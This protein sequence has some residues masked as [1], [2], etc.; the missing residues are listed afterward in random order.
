MIFL[1]S[2]SSVMCGAR[3]PLM[4]ENLLTSLPELIENTGYLAS[5][6]LEKATEK[7]LDVDRTAPQLPAHQPNPNFALPAGLHCRTCKVN[8]NW[9][10]TGARG[11]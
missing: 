1:I 9:R 4:N 8:G 6:E 7:L 3:F 2:L 10:L 11:A 5:P